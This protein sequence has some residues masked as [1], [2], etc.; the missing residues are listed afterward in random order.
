MRSSSATHARAS[1][2]SAVSRS[3]ICAQ[4]MRVLLALAPFVAWMEPRLET[5]EARELSAYLHLCS[6]HPDTCSDWEI[7]GGRCA[8]WPVSWHSFHEGCGPGDSRLLNQDK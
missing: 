6:K 7:Q 4:S 5:R 3:K 8:A 2:W 1:S